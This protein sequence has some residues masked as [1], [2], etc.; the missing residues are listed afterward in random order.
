MLAKGNQ[1]ESHHLQVRKDTCGV[2]DYSL[3]PCVF[4][5]RGGGLPK[6]IPLQVDGR[7]ELHPSSVQS[8]FPSSWCQRYPQ[9]GWGP[10][11]SL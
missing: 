11:G 2:S 8:C 9:N 5:F 10:F 7:S 3:L 1:K 6:E 4:L